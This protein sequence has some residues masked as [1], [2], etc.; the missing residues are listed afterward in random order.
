MCSSSPVLICSQIENSVV[1]D[2]DPHYFPKLD[3]GWIRIRVKR[4]IRIRVEVK[5]WIRI[6]IGIIMMPIHKTPTLLENAA[7]G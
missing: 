4:W 6:Y 1:V 5:S 2:P 3:L 7:C